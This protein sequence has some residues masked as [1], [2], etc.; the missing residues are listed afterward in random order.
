MWIWQPEWHALNLVRQPTNPSIL[1]NVKQDNYLPICWHIIIIFTDLLAL[2]FII[3]P[4]CCH[5][6][7]IF[8]RF[9]GT[10]IIILPICW[11]IIIIF[12]DLLAFLL[13]FYRFVGTLLFYWFIWHIYYYFT[14]FVVDTWIIFHQIVRKFPVHLIF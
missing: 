9:I 11:H 4:I 7:I 12:T 6:I 14:D 13:L 10:F 8:Y 1:C 2:F 3:L 5:I